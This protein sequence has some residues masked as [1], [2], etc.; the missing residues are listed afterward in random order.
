[1]RRIIAIL[2]LSI[3]LYNLGGYITLHQYLSYCSEKLFNQQAAKGLYNSKDLE[4]VQVPVNLPGIRDWVKYENISG[5][6]RF[7]DNAYNYVQMRV[8]S[9]VLFLKCIPNYKATRL[10]TQNILHATPIKDIP[11]SQKEHVPYAG[12]LLLNALDVN[13]VN[14][15][16][17]PPVTM[18]A[19]ANFAYYQQETDHY[20]ILP[21][22][23]PKFVC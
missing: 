12:I 6:I 16:F 5:Q 22:Q 7:G 17:E 20:I 15:V 19:P 18:V 21:K 1:L 8:T 11:V 4:E 10:N 9:Y 13:F 3:H 2:L 23:P 14:A